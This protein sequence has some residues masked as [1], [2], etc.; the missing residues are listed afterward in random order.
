[1]TNDFELNI[2]NKFCCNLWRNCLYGTS[3]ILVKW[4]VDVVV[5]SCYF[6]VHPQQAANKNLLFLK[7]GKINRFL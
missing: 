5:F 4:G 6:T 2:L 7:S 3:E 1:M